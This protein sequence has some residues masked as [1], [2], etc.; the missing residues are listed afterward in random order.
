[1]MSYIDMCTIVFGISLYGQDS[2]DGGWLTHIR[3][4]KKRL[5]IAIR[6]GVTMRDY[7]TTRHMQNCVVYEFI[8]IQKGLF[9]F[10]INNV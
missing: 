2:S 7:V 8:N 4:M 1:M 5:C 3:T 6:T 9:I 10:L